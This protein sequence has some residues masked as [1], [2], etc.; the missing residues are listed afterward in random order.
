[1]QTHPACRFLL[2][3]DCQAR[4][5]GAGYPIAAFSVALGR[6]MAR[7]AQFCRDLCASLLGDY[8]MRLNM[9]RTSFRP[10]EIEGRTSRTVGSDVKLVL[11]SLDYLYS[12]ALP[13]VS[14][15]EI[16][17]P[18]LTFSMRLTP[19]QVGSF[20]LR[21]DQFCGYSHPDLMGDFLVMTES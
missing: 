17:V 6:M 8:A 3:V 18:D 16:A 11:H 5:F 9:A 21:G 12:L 2:A 14:L 15:K 7:Y 1:M 13:H 4:G 20:E 10:V 19:E